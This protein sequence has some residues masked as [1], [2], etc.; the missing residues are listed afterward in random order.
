[1]VQGDKKRPRSRVAQSSDARFIDQGYLYA[2]NG[3]R[4]I[5]GYVPLVEQS[6]FLDITDVPTQHGVLIYNKTTG[7]LQLSDPDNM[8][9]ICFSGSVP[10]VVSGSYASHI[11]SLD[12]NTNGLLVSPFFTIG[13]VASPDSLGV[14]FYT[15]S[16]DNDTNRDITR[17]NT[18]D[19]NLDT[20]QKITD[21]QSGEVTVKYYNGNNVLIHTET[22]SLDGSLNDQVSTPQGYLE[23]NSLQR[24]FDR[25]EG[26]VEVSLPAFSLLGG[27]GYVQ[28]VVEHIVDSASYSQVIDYFLDTGTAPSINSQNLKMDAVAIKWLSGIKFAGQGSSV[29]FYL[30]AL[31]V[32]KDTYRTDP[33]LVNSIEYGINNFVIN[34]NNVDVTSEGVNPPVL[35]FEHADDFIYSG[36]KSINNDV[37]NPDEDN[38]FAQMRYVV[39]D[40]F[41]TSNGSLFSANP[42][43]LINTFGNQSTD[44]LELFLDEDY[45]MTNA[46]GSVVGI[47]GPSRGARSWDS[48]M[49]LIS[50]TGLQVINGLLVFPQVDFSSMDPLANRDYTSIVGEGTDKVYI[51]QFKDSSGVSRTNGVFRI[52][53][54]TEV[55]RTSKEVL[56][57]IRVVGTHIPG[58]GVQGP[59]NE[60]TDWLSLNDPYNIGTFTGD[61]G[62]G[63]FVNTGGYLAPEFEFTFG[64]FSTAFAENKAIEARVTLKNPEAV[65]T[66]ITRMEIINWT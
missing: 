49:T 23:I 39:R 31:E 22:L 28:I 50:G 40:P 9:W 65:S 61:V 37:I 38:N 41:F 6:D 12:G 32:W 45:R 57:E 2:E 64:G 15:N 59:G 3:N 63:C 36:T 35:P 11:G 44:T 52:A 25:I 42:E 5:I 47:N 54:L 29:E 16:W 17:T 62:D 8:Q 14:P 55:Q 30:D 27:T 66:V 26:F 7:C 20:G 19:W 33:I 51:R 60:G 10:P 53:G 18:L 58:N 56:V 4:D 43:I 21:L 1:M 24:N 46:S 34:Y 13:R 48:T